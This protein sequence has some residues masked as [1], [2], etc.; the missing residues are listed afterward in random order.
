ML[1]VGHLEA[2]LDLVD[3][4]RLTIVVVAAAPEAHARPEEDQGE[5][6]AQPACPLE[7]AAP[8]R[9]KMRRRRGA[10]HDAVGEELRAA[11]LGDREGLQHDEEHEHV[12]EREVSSRRRSRR[13]RP[14]PARCSPSRRGCR[15]NAIEIATQ[16]MLVIAA[17]LLLIVPPR[18]R[19]QRRSI[20]EQ[21]RDAR[22]RGRPGVDVVV[23]AGRRRRCGS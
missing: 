19:A 21:D 12:V 15:R 3:E 4:L 8:A 17:A 10:Q 1:A 18:P 7:A 6:D 16:T 5:R 13:G 23:G 20:T 11:R 2:A 9:M 14:W 22:R